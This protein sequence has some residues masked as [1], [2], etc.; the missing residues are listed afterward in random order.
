VRRSSF[1]EDARPSERTRARAF[2]R[3]DASTSATGD[4]A[5]R[6]GRKDDDDD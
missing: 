6:G 4:D 3:A 1:V 5:R 2:D